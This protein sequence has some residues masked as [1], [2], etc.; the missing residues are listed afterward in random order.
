MFQRTLNNQSVIAASLR[1]S[2]ALKRPNVSMN[3]RTFISKAVDDF[4]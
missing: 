3:R 1:R 4:L 2:R